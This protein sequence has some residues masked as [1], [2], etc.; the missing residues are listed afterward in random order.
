M[1]DPDFTISS[2]VRTTSQ[3]AFDAMIS[4][5]GKNCSL[6]T[7]TS[8]ECPNCWFDKGNNKSSN[9]YKTGGP[10][11]FNFGICPYCKGLGKSETETTVVIKMLTF[12][13]KSKNF[14]MLAKNFKD[15]RV[16]G[17][18][19]VT[20]GYY[21]DIPKIMK[22]HKMRVDS[23][24]GELQTS[25]TGIKFYEYKLMAPPM[26]INSMIQGRYFICAWEQL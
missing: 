3:A 2:Q 1:S 7:V 23:G 15:L 17:G 11:S 12:D 8:S 21:S 18:V 22:A 6:I 16:E 13:M 9:R 26:D 20:K 14:D 24:T 4:Q 25:V 19:L 5:W 10:I